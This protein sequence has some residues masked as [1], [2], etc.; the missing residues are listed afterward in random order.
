MRL[1]MPRL[2]SMLGLATLLAVA[3]ALT[4]T[5][6]AQDDPAPNAATAKERK[7]SEKA[8]AAL[9]AWGN[10]MH[11]PSQ[12]T[13][14]EI[15]ASASAAN[16]SMFQ[17]G[18]LSVRATW[19][20]DGG[21][22]L[23]V[24]L[25]KEMTETMPPQAVAMAKSLFKR[26]SREALAPAFEAP[27]QY[28]ADYHV[29]ERKEGERSVVELL[30]FTDH[31]AAELQLLYFDE[32]GLCERRIMIP[33]V[34]PNDPSQQMMMGVEIETSFGYQKVGERSVLKRMSMLLPFGEMLVEY[35]YYE[36]T[37]GPP[38][39]KT[40]R[41][42]TPFAPDPIE[43]T[44]HDYTLDGNE[45]AETKQKVEEEAADESGQEPHDEKDDS[46]D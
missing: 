28:A 14:S 6:S 40:V 22:E 17:G 2:S 24:T 42:A 10:A 8:L 33:R 9:K 37:D 30:P 12:S 4:T 18:D 38:L 13:A 36:V 1:P 25:P 32:N 19:K 45:V 15:H 11:L 44:L 20:R 34:D 7:V 16:E 21:L 41:M 3:P 35:D 26:W 23:D 46:E 43:V 5:T 27:M 29:N 31:A 39:L